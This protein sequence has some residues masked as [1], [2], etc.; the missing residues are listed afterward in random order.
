M[1]VPPCSSAAKHNQSRKRPTCKAG[2]SLLIRA[3]IP[4]VL[5]TRF[6]KFCTESLPHEQPQAS[7]SSNACLTP[8]LPCLL[9]KYLLFGGGAPPDTKLSL[10]LICLPHGSIAHTGP[11]S[12]QTSRDAK[13]HCTCHRN[14]PSLPGCS[15]EL[16]PRPSCSWITGRNQGGEGDD[17][18]LICVSRWSL[19][20]RRKTLPRSIATRPGHPSLHKRKDCT[21]AAY[22]CG[23]RACIRHDAASSQAAQ[24]PGHLGART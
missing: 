14:V 20:R 5:A 19:G 10:K 11:T 1:P 24:L 16:P 13:P 15:A 8:R 6:K 23:K 17:G 9:P 21:V 12:C 3:D 2:V 22:I 7:C 18:A 4:R